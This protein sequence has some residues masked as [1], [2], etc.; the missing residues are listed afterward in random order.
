MTTM[1][2][3]PYFLLPIP[4]LNTKQFNQKRSLVIQAPIRVEMPTPFHAQSVNAFLFTT[5]E[6]VLVDTGDSNPDGRAALHAALATQ[7]LTLADIQKV[8]ITHAHV[9]HFGQ[10]AEILAASGAQLYVGAVGAPWLLQPQLMWQRRIDFYAGTFLPRVG[11]PQMQREM[12]LAFMTHVRDAAHPIPPA[13]MTILPIGATIDLGG[14]PWQLLHTP[15][16]ATHQTVL[17]QAQ[18]GMFLGGDMLLQKTPT[19]VVEAPP[20][21]ADRVPALPHFMHSLRRCAALPIGTVYPGHGAPFSDHGALITRQEARIARRSVEALQLV[22]AGERTLPTLLQ[23]MYGHLPPAAQF[24]GLW[25]L[26]G[27]LDL[28]EAEGRVAK[29]LE[30][31]IWHYSPVV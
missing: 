27:Y 21:G 29:S 22:A 18:T 7:N 10:A 24:A 3:I 16:H 8:V 12:I 11:L 19:P 25:M 4:R 31:G 17:W 14:R 30:N 26:I 9:D 2:R 15:G 6:V 23:A 5:P 1:C 13:Q 20:A 28:L